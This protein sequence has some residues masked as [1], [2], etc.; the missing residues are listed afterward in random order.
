[1]GIVSVYQYDYEHHPYHHYNSLHYICPNYSSHTSLIIERFINV[2]SGF[3]YT[4]L[5]KIKMYGKT[6]TLTTVV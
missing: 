6:W 3:I 5:K 2:H 4:V 1:M